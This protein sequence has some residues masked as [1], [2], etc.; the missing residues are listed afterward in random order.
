MGNDIYA[1]LIQEYPV[2]FMA[3]GAMPLPHVDESLKAIRYCLD[4][5]GFQ[6]MAANSMIGNCKNPDKLIYPGNELLEPIYDELNRR[7]AILYFHPT[8]SGA[9]SPMVNSASLE[10]VTGAPIED[11]LVILHLL[12]ADIPTR[13]PDIKL[14]I[15][16][17]GG[18]IPFLAQRIQD[19]FED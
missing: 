13:Y 14:H 10:W 5:L 18:D 3:Y 4:T 2:R 6:G 7:R 8:G 19:N 16:H 12:R 17:L 15:A 11:Q 1:G 9:C